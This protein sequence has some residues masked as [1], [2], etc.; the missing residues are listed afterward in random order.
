LLITLLWILWGSA[1]PVSLPEWVEPPV[2]HVLQQNYL[3]WQVKEDVSQRLVASHFNT[4]W[5]FTH[6]KNRNG[7]IMGNNWVDPS[8]DEAMCQWSL[9]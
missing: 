5:V 2:K 8:L 3:E 1:F 6:I 9:L 4:F 7:G